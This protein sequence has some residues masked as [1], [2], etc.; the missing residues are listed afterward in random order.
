MYMPLKIKQVFYLTWRHV[1]LRT[2][3]SPKKHL[4]KRQRIL[5]ALSLVT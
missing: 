2:Q 3:Q 4:L 5:N 1:C